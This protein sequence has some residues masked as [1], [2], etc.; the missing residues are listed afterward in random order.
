MLNPS[1]NE[2]AK[3]GDSRYTLVMLTAKRARKIIEGAEPLVET[4]SKKPV[5]IAL[6][7]VIE[8]KITYTRP[9]INSIK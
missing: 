1:F 4:S 6:Q 9:P 2:L 5:S 8:G 7:E 3:R